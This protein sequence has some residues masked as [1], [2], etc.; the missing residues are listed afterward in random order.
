[1][2]EVEKLTKR[3]RDVLNAIAGGL[4]ERE[5]CSKLRLDEI[6]TGRL[7]QSII[8]KMQVLEPKTLEDYQLLLGYERIERRRLEG[9]VWAGEARL[10]ALMDTAP[11]AIFLVAGRSGRILKA[12]NNAVLMFGYSPRELIGMVME[13]LI[14]PNKRGI[15]ELY[16]TNFLNSTRKREMGYHPPIHALCKDGTKLRLD[17]ALTATKKTDDV[18]VVCRQAD[19]TAPAEKHVAEERAK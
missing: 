15:H 8:V 10:D 3:E 5:A 9:E 1:L 16:R 18:M 17:I 7:W 19:P 13:E 12:N 4:T 6:E 11:E 2:I 14:V